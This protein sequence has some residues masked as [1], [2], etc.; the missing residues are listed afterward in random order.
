[1]EQQ[2]TIQRLGTMSHG[3]FDARL[4]Q[5]WRPDYPWVRPHTAPDPSLTTSDF[6][7]YAAHAL[8]QGIEKSPLREPMKRQRLDSSRNVVRYAAFEILHASVQLVHL[9]Q[10]APAAMTAVV[11]KDFRDALALKSLRTTHAYSP[12]WGEGQKTPGDGRDYFSLRLDSKWDAQFL[13]T[14]AGG[15]I[16]NSADTAPLHTFLDEHMSYLATLDRGEVDVFCED[17]RNRLLRT[18]DSHAFL[19]DSLRSRILQDTFDAWIEQEGENQKYLAQ[20]EKLFAGPFFRIQRKPV[21]AALDPATVNERIRLYGQRPTGSKEARLERLLD[22]ETSDARID[23]TLTANITDISSLPLIK[24][25]IDELLASET[26]EPTLRTKIRPMFAVLEW[27]MMDTVARVASA[28]QEETIKGQEDARRSGIA[29]A[30]ALQ[31]IIQHIRTV[32]PIRECDH[33]NFG[34]LTLLLCSQDSRMNLTNIR[35][36]L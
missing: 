27:L 18:L 34:L 26:H 29:A 8:L 33:P 2:S 4:V 12:L 23:K 35:T 5:A 21:L 25:Y 28:Q 6:A 3:E 20:A 7:D 16:R 10:Q 13:E 31:E 14:L 24:Q 9:R 15:N 1:M 11:R 22:L 17:F 36:H 19:D 32:L 30:I